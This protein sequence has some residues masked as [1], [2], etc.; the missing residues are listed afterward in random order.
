MSVMPLPVVNYATLL[1]K[2]LG[3]EH[4]NQK[5]RTLF[6]FMGKLR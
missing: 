2:V 4:G 6:F 1:N 3:I 5:N